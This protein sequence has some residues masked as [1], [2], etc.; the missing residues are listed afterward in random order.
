MIKRM[1]SALVA[2]MIAL[3]IVPAFAG[4]ICPHD[5]CSMGIKYLNEREYSH[6]YAYWYDVEWVSEKDCW[7]VHY[8]KSIRMERDVYYVCSHD[9]SHKQF[10]R[11]EQYTKTICTKTETQTR[12]Q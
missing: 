6:D 7:I 10:I 12:P 11:T 9:S 1:I 2:L 4:P 8:Y 3:A 5:S